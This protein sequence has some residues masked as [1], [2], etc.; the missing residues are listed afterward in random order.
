MLLNIEDD[1][2]PNIA[3]KDIDI[4]EEIDQE[5]LV[6]LDQPREFTFLELDIDAVIA[7]YSDNIPDFDIY[8]G[9]L[10]SYFEV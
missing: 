4:I 5:E 2:I 8:K 7:S 10:R 9:D 1:F 3:H 6:R